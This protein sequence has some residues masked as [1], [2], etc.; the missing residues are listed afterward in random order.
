MTEGKK[1]V[2]SNRCILDKAGVKELLLLIS[3]FKQV[4][5]Q[6]QTFFSFIVAMIRKSKKLKLF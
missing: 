1:C 4:Q 3:F 2:V 5:R 6:T